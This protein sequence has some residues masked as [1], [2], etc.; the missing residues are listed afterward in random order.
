M[1]Q[2]FLVLVFLAVANVCA[3]SRRANCLQLKCQPKKW[4]IL[5]HFGDQA[6]NFCAVRQ[7]GRAGFA[8]VIG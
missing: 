7:A 6:R 3:I 4:A 5:G 8:D 2:L 1:L